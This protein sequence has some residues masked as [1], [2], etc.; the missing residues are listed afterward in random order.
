M[1]CMVFA[2]FIPECEDGF[3]AW[4][5]FSESIKNYIPLKFTRNCWFEMEGVLLCK[6]VPEGP[7]RFCVR[8][9][10][11]V[12]KEFVESVI[13]IFTH[14]WWCLMKGMLV[15]HCSPGVNPNNRAI[16]E[17]LLPLE[18]V[19]LSGLAHRVSTKRIKGCGGPGCPEVGAVKMQNVLSALLIPA[20]IHWLRALSLLPEGIELHIT[21]GLAE[22]CRF[23]VEAVLLVQMVLESIDR[24]CF[25]FLHRVRKEVEETFVYCLAL[26]ARSRVVGVLATR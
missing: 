24:F 19:R 12:G 23:K 16:I 8:N 11:S 2:G 6:H 7:N 18:V 13:N 4:L 14:P 17:H 20:V 3:C 25:R 22:A 26:P 15:L 5:L 10:F 21:L 1:D 9:L